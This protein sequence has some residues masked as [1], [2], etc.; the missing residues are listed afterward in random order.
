MTFTTER[1]VQLLPAV[2][3]LRDG[4]D[5]PLRELLDVVAEQ[6]GVLEENLDQLYSDQF[7]ETCSPWVLPYL[8]DLLGITGLPPSPLTRRAEVAHTIAYRRRKGTAAILEQLARDVTGLPA[9][10]VEFFELLCAT[11]H[12]NHLRPECRGFVSLGDARRLENPPRPLEQQPSDALRLEDLGGPFERLTGR[13]TLTHTVDVRRIASGRGRYNVSNVG[14]FLWRLRAQRLTRSPATPDTDGELRKFRFSPLGN[15]A[16][17][18]NRPQTEDDVT[19]LAEPRNVPGRISRRA[20]DADLSGFYGD[21]RSLLIEN[22]DAPVPLA[23]VRICNLGDWTAPSDKIAIDPVLGR[24]VFPADADDPRVTFHYGFSANIGGGEYERSSSEE[25]AGVAVV[26][27]GTDPGAIQTAVDA[28]PV[29][30]GVV[31]ITNSGRYEET[32]LAID[33]T[34]RRIIVRAS[35]GS[36]PTLAL[37][38]NLVIGGD[39]AGAVVLDGLLISGG[40]VEVEAPAADETGLG[41]L[42]LR[43]AAL[44][45][46]IALDTDG[47]PASAD[48]SLLVHSPV[49]TVTI[50]HS[51]VGGVRADSGVRVVVTEGVV[52]ATGEAEIAFA[53]PGGADD[54]GGTLTL[55]QVT[56]IGRVKADALRLVSNT[57]LL[58][59]LPEGVDPDEWPGPVVARRRQEGCVRFS[60]VPR[61]SRTP[62]RYHCQPER[63]SDA[64]GLEPILTS[65]RYADP[66]YCQLADAT[67]SLI[68]EGADDESELGAFH[69]LFLPRREAHLRTRLDEHL[70]FGLE[71]GVFHAT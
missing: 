49:A 32:G 18:F 21:D 58:A 69:H 45:P 54:F 33:A 44:V 28:L 63:A 25:A 51:V 55:E 60:Y 27:A 47:T 8:G 2:Y 13:V 68:R 57:I 41:A 65:A 23:D 5:G 66:G 24:L 56:V 43:H 31:E 64:A 26:E 20:A 22:A 61:G 6:L 37:D 7:V 29:E 4:D 14:I 1:L 3:G 53:A 36:R 34:G 62:R 15:D 17:L 9:R 59:E 42:E 19:H 50:N 30:G 38:G 40:A 52:D 70:R 71:A 48:P 16:P 10:A 46:G 35:L 67:S 11:Q 12:L 39:D